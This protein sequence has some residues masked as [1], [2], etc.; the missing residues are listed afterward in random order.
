ME[1]TME[2][3]MNKANKDIHNLETYVKTESTKNS[4]I[5]LN[6]FKEKFEELYKIYNQFICLKSVSFNPKKKYKHKMKSIYVYK[7]VEPTGTIIIYKNYIDNRKINN[8]D[9]EYQG[10]WKNDLRHGQG[11][12]YKNGIFIRDCEYK[13]DNLYIKL[14]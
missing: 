6:T 8:E 12:I 1:P 4:Y 13:N 7:K 11:K 9:G 10:Q 3:I 5:Y 14:K 2:T